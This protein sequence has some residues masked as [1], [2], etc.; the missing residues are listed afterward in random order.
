MKITAKKL[1]L[2]DA[3]GAITTAL[4]LSQVLTRFESFFG[5]PKNYLIPLALAAAVFALYSFSCFLFAK[6]H[7]NNLLKII[8]IINSIYCLITLSLIFLLF[9]QLTIWGIGYFLGEIIIVLILVQA[10]IRFAMIN[11]KT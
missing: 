1:F 7:Q 10:E 9:E 11:N 4:L 3:L 2:I 6:A 8:A 5:M